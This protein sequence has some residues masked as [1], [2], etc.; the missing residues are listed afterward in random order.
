MTGLKTHEAADIVNTLDLVG[1]TLCAMEEHGLPPAHIQAA[2]I[3]MVATIRANI[4]SAHGLTIDPT[5]AMR[6][7]RRPSASDVADQILRDLDND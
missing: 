7:D 5:A 6:M 4:E 3:I 2:L 1:M